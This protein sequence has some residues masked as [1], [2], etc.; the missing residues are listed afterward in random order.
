MDEVIQI[1]R[2]A[3]KPVLPTGQARCGVAE[4]D[5][6]PHVGLPMAG[7]SSA[8]KVAQGLRGR[9]FARAFYLEDAAGHCAA[10]CVL[11][12]MSASRYLLE[13]AASYT[14][15]VSGIAV[16]RL[17]LAGTHTHTG[18]GQFYGNSLYDTFAQCEPG[19]DQALADWLAARL[20]TAVNT[21]A[22]TAV[23]AQVGIAVRP[24]WGVSRNRSLLAF[25]PNHDAAQ[26]HDPGGP[27]HGAPAGLSAEQR[28]VDPRV[29]VL[30]A[31]RQDSGALL[32]VFAT[33]GCHATSLGLG[34]EVYAPDWAGPA[35]RTA[36]RLLTTPNTEPPIVAV[37]ASAGGDV[38][39]L[40]DDMDQG[41]ALTRH[42]G[43]L[44]G[45]TIA[46]AAHEASAQRQ[47]FT[48][49]VR[50]AEPRL[51]ERR[52]DNRADTA[53]AADWSF[54]APTLGG[55]EDGRTFFHHAGLVYE[56]MTSRHFRPSDPQYPKA[57]ALGVLQDV[58]VHHLLG[59]APAPALP[60]YALKLAGHLFVT[61]PGEPTAMAAYRIERALQTATGVAGVT[62]L[63]YAG[64][65]GGYYTTEEEYR[66]QHYEG[67]HTLYGRNAVRHV[68]ARLEQL[69]MGPAPAP[70][71][72]GL[73]VFHPR[74]RVKN[75]EAAS[76]GG[77]GE[78]P[79]P[80]VTRKGLRVEVRWHMPASVRVVFAEGY[81]VRLEERVNGRWQP[82]QH[83]G[84][85]FD[86][87]SEEIEILRRTDLFDW[88]GS[89]AAWTIELRLPW[90]PTADRRLRVRVA[91]HAEFP[92]FTARI[93]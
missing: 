47:D 42:A 58:L 86:D 44:V 17:I 10:L 26:W 63:G 87:V 29:T 61:V 33:F 80:R 79:T 77:A 83:Y 82:V 12:L 51:S 28:A 78:K 50:Y 53:L 31:T 8:G 62:V 11:D 75:F 66:A 13:R 60:L 5:I 14:A 76:T 18:P 70:L 27:G 90:E 3:A 88:L 37:A 52:V 20:A 36:R 32:G 4:V 69:V 16:D 91:P 49:E 72:P 30:T 41:P 56:G 23:P 55:S 57:P 2:V 34:T 35:V 93:P 9:L 59:L 22:Q 7:Y 43:T 54:G 48:V 67:A 21:A 15:P 84:H 89:Q 45:Q 92:G 64:D 46:E 39:A 81:F 73:V 19:F 68:S 25:Q 24:L 74:A 38:N 85:D 65:Y 40:R 6:T 1:A 71:G